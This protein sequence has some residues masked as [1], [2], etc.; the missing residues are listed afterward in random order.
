[1]YKADDDMYLFVFDDDDL[2]SLYQKISRRYFVNEDVF[3]RMGS[4]S[5]ILGK[6]I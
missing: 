2:L 6:N 4:S 3:V 1:M 5:R